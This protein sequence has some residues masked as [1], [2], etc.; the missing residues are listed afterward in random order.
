MAVS[1]LANPYDFANPV[2]DPSLFV[3]RTKEMKE[4]RYYLDQATRVPRPINLAILGARASGKT[5][6]LNMIEIEAK[7]RGLLATRIDL[8]EGDV[9]TQL[10][11]FCKVFDSILTTACDSGIFG[12]I[13]GKTYEVYRDMVDA[14]EVPEDKTFCP[15]VFP[16]QY[17]KAMASGNVAA[18][19]SETGLKPDLKK[20]LEELKSSMVI[21]FDECDV[22][23]KSRVHLEKVRN[24]FMNMPGIM[25]VMS[26][27][28]ALFLLIDEVFSPIITQFKKI[29]LERFEEEQDTENCIRKPLEKMGA[30]DV[31]ELFDFESYQDV[32]E[33][34]NISGGRPY[35]IQLLCHI[36]FRRVQE[37]RAESMEITMDAL[38]EVRMELESHQDVPARPV[39]TAVQDLD[40]KGL[41]ALNLLCQC[42][43]YATWKQMWFIEFVCNGEEKFTQEEFSEQFDS[44]RE[45]GIIT[46]G[47]KGIIDFVGDD[48]DRIYVKYFA[49]RE[50][51][52]LA[53]GDLSFKLMLLIELQYLVVRRLK[54]IRLFGGLIDGTLGE[55][56]IEEAV[57]ML[58]EQEGEKNSFKDMPGE[59]S[60]AYKAMMDFRVAGSFEAARVT[61]RSPWSTVQQWY[62]F[63]SVEAAKQNL[64]STM[65][66][67]LSEVKERAARVDGELG[68]EIHEL[69][70]VPVKILREAV[71]ASESAKVKENLSLWHSNQMFQAYLK[72]HNTEE[73]IFHGELAC[74]YYPSFSNLNN[75]GYLFMVSGNLEKAKELLQRS[76]EESKEP[77]DEAL[78]TYNL[79]IVEAKENKSKSALDKFELAIDKAR[80][81]EKRKRMYACLIQPKIV[82]R[83]LAFEQVEEVDLLET[84]QSAACTMRKLSDIQ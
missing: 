74:E 67:L 68:I 52:S 42:N 32:K 50:S 83:E 17:A 79:G 7:E 72:Q 6:T 69:P 58:K 80:C 46:A 55:E 60:A 64:L 76:I 62:R 1:D 49:R 65:Q 30:M 44:L 28:S 78:S 19:L 45:K 4:V 21:L 77:M 43:G 39:L 54:E 59:A 10:A 2:I 16:M 37:G 66:S 14:Y 18:T 40:R 53:I 13:K 25:L 23:T 84:A 27:S 61:I 33:V 26:G 70:V 15:F 82:D 20:I 41:L 47:E 35:E 9:Q 22:L 31:S 34:H 71:E 8:D 51:V 81:F 48:F 75:L 73:A 57:T 29:Y 38:D 63:R 24:L 36:M 56:R 3:G 5:S 11:F 12:G